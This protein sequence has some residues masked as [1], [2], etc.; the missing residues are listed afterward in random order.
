MADF[1]RGIKAG[2][3]TGIAYIAISAILGAIY[4]NLLSIPPFIHA[5]QLSPFL[6]R[7]LTAFSFWLSVFFPYVCRGLVFGAVFA[8]LYS[9]LPGTASVK[10]GVMLS[11]FVC[12][13]ALVGAIYTTPGWPTEGQISDGFY[14][15]GT[16]KLSSPSLALAGIISALV[17]GTLTGFLW[18]RFRGKRLTEERKGRSVLLVSFILGLVTWVLFAVMFLIG[19]VIRGAPAIGIGSLWPNLLFL[20]VVFLG[21]PGWVLTLVAWRKTKVDKSGFK[22]GVAGGVMMALTGIMLFPGIL[23]IIGGVLSGRQP[24]SEPSTAA[25]VQ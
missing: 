20:S 5:A 16:L 8:A 14:Y 24:A 23:A 12:I 1:G 4:Y 15:A 3:V 13:V 11:A 6:L 25:I 9:F 10:K 17:F 19:V 7:D 18:D 21:L 22:W 2:V